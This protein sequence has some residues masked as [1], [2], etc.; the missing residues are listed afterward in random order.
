MVRRSSVELRSLLTQVNPQLWSYQGPI[1][2]YWIKFQGTALKNNVDLNFSFYEHIKEW[3]R[4]YRSGKVGNS[5]TSLSSWVTLCNQTHCLI[6]EMKLIIIKPTLMNQ[7]ENYISTCQALEK[8]SKLLL[9][10]LLLE[11]TTERLTFSTFNS[12]VE[13]LPSINAIN[14]LATH[15]PYLRKVRREEVLKDTSMSS[16]ISVTWPF[17]SSVTCH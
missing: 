1:N 6:C 10:L 3:W 11:R 12:V 8:F 17:I 15:S 7:Y 9:L 16:L 14:L 5:A 13:L 4:S 2:V